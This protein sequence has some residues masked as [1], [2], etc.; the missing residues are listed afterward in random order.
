MSQKLIDY[1]RAIEVASLQMLEAAKADD[2]DGVVRLEGTCADRAVA[3]RVHHAGI[4]QG[5][6]HGIVR[7]HV[8]HPG[9]RCPDSLPGRALDGAFREEV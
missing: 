1:Y 5:Q 6:S 8:A 7:H 3:L 2:W 4:A 9:Q